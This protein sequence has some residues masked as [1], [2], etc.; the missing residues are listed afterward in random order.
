LN[1][2]DIAI[3]A[4]LAWFTFAAFHAGL[5]REVVTILGAIFAVALAGIF[6]QE[7]AKDVKVAVDSEAT[8]QVIAFALIFGAVILGSQLIAVFLK[9]TSQL[10]MLGLLDSFGGAIIG[11]IKGLIFVEIGLIVALTF[12]SLGLEDDVKSSELAVIFLDGLPFLR[13][14]L[15]Q[16]FKNSIDSF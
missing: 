10:L 13:L 6:Y 3:L 12:T 16:E 8:A 14:I 15:P 7:L 11:L 5:I 4:I 2:V 9:Q 1:W